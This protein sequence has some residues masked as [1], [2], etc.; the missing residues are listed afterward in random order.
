M[1]SKLVGFWIRVLKV[2]KLVTEPAYFS[3]KPG[4]QTNYSADRDA[5]LILVQVLN[6]KIK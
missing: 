3:R 5:V 6:P 1:T 4:Q 2:N